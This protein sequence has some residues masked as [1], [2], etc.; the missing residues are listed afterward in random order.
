MVA[1]AEEGT[2][3]LGYLGSL[4]VRVS[5]DLNISIKIVKIL[6]CRYFFVSLHSNLCVDVLP[7]G[8]VLNTLGYNDGISK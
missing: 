7:I 1:Q 2:P 3:I 8:V 4:E 6:W 5:L